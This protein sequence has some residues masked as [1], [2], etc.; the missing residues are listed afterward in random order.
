MSLPGIIVIVGLILAFGFLV[1]KV[2]NIN[3]VS[4]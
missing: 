4:M 3:M 1:K 2:K